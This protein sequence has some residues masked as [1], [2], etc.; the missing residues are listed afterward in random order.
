MKNNIKNNILEDYKYNLDYT[1]F[2]YNRQLHQPERNSLN[3]EALEAVVFSHGSLSLYEHYK[4]GHD[5]KSITGGFSRIGR[6]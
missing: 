2:T 1:K 6:R 4:H 3:K 5:A